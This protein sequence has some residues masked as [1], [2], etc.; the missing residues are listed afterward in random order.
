[1]KKYKIK[2]KCEGVVNFNE[3][4]DWFFPNWFNREHFEDFANRKF[5]DKQFEDIKTF[6]VEETNMCDEISR[7]VSEYINE[8]YEEVL[9][10][11]KI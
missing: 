7:I 11:D 1:M 4:K 3:I 2:E 9:K 8:F 5:T 10:G 6:L